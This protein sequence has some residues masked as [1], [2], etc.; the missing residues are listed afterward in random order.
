MIRHFK[1]EAVVYD[2]IQKCFDSDNYTSLKEYVYSAI[3]TNELQKDGNYGLAKQTLKALLKKRIR[4]LENVFSRMTLSDIHHLKFSDTDLTMRD[5][6]VMLVELRNSGELCVRICRSEGIVTFQSSELA[7][8]SADENNTMLRTM[9]SR[10]EESLAQAARIRS[11]QSSLYKNPAYVS[12]KIAGMKGG[13]GG[14]DDISN[15]PILSD[16]MIDY[17]DFEDTS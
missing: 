11:I 16:M 8:P 13:G 1:Q 15:N 9:T 6:E 17:D 3:A 10:L 12:K 7:A 14:P 2:T 4:C 5:I